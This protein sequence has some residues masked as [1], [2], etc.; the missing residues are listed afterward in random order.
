MLSVLN[1][2]LFPGEFSFVL[3]DPCIEGVNV[4]ILNQA[5]LKVGE[6]LVFAAR[7]ECQCIMLDK[8]IDNFF[9][10]LLP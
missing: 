6:M 10:I 7:S 4:K 5:F 1:V 8:L 2:Q 3:L 9:K